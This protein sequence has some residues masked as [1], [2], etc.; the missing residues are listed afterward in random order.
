MKLLTA[1]EQAVAQALS[2]GAALVRDQVDVALAHRLAVF[3]EPRAAGA[4]LQ[5]LSCDASMTLVF[6]QRDH[7]IGAQGLHEVVAQAALVVGLGFPWS[8]R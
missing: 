5:K 2:L 4:L 3:G 7:R 1:G 8:S 6:E